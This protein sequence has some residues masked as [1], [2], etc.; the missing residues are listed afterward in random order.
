MP[1]VGKVQ[2]ISFEIRYPMRE[3][4]P[5]HVHAQHAEF[6]AKISIRDAEITE[7]RLPSKVAS[8]AKRWV[9][10]HQDELLEIWDRAQR[11]ETWTQIRD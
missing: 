10:D 7:G 1:K 8:T 6:D 3:H 2:G 5:P 9:A 4:P 11:H